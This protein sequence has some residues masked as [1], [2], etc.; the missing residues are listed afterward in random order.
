MQLYVYMHRMHCKTEQYE[1]QVKYRSRAGMTTSTPG[2]NT[3][4]VRFVFENQK[5][6]AGPPRTAMYTSHP[7]CPYP[8]DPSLLDRRSSSRSPPKSQENSSMT[9]TL[10]LWATQITGHSDEAGLS[11]NPLNKHRQYKL[12]LRL[13]GILAYAVFLNKYVFIMWGC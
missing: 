13:I 7:R 5:L 1:F 6:S 11:S 2:Y 10:W 12:T 3:L 8:H 9:T 4:P